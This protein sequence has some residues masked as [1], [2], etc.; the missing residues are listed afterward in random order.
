MNYSWTD[1]DCSWSIFTGF[2]AG[3]STHQ[4]T[5]ILPVSSEDFQSLFIEFSLIARQIEEKTPATSRAAHH[6]VTNRPPV[7]TRS[8]RLLSDELP[9]TKSEFDLLLVND[10]ARPLPQTLSTAGTH[11]EEGASWQPCGDYRALDAV[12]RYPR[13]TTTVSLHDGTVPLKVYFVWV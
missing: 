4:I 3:T 11:K 8:R 10:I 5:V 7:T 1:A 6:T 9:Y 2:E 12:T 13:Y